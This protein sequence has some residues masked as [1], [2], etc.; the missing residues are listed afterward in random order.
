MLKTKQML[1]NL[2]S[3]LQL[4]FGHFKKWFATD[5]SDHINFLIRTVFQLLN[6]RHLFACRS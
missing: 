6:R 1:D 4:S 3:R 2:V 5:N